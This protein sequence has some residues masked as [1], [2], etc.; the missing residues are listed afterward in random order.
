MHP[1]HRV[2][3]VVW[4]HGASIATMAAGSAVAAPLAFPGAEGFA[5]M[6]TGGRKG[7][8]VHVTTLADSGSGSLRD[9]VSQGNRIVVFDVSGVI[10]PPTSLS[11]LATTSPWRARAPRV[12]ASPSMAGKPASAA[13]AT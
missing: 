5:A 3:V 11:S 2:F 13:A 10:K 7:Q 4:H 9:A 8:V 1:F 12:M 6:V